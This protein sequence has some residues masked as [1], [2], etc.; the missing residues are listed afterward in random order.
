[1][2]RTTRSSTA[3]SGS[4]KRPAF[5]QQVAGNLGNMKRTT[6]S[7]TAR[8]GST[9][10]T[11]FEQQ[12]T[13]AG[14]MVNMKRT[15][16][17]S[18]A[19]SGSTKRTAFEQQGAPMHQKA[20]AQLMATLRSPSSHQQQVMLQILRSNPPLM[21]IFIKQRTK[22]YLTTVAGNLGNMEGTTTRHHHLGTTAVTSPACSGG[23]DRAAFEQRAQELIRQRLVLLL[24]AHQCQRRESQANGET[25]QCRLPQCQII[26]PVLNH[27]KSCQAGNECTVTHCSSSR[28]VF[29]HWK[30]CNKNDCP[31]CEPLN[32]IFLFIFYSI[33]GA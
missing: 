2:K 3:R 9:K 30:H 27:L 12:V 4:I 14:N 10:R 21:E 32:F 5:E 16:R 33:T 19:R 20:L 11:A 18:T 28:Q 6:R 7:S 31:V 13:L 25:W 23:T 29:S 24:H 26:K 8:S 1:M 17:S 15:T 22:E